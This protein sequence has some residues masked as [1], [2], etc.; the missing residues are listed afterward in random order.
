MVAIDHRF[1]VGVAERRI[2]RCF[3]DSG[4]IKWVVQEG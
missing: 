3:Q 1:N 2:S 4:W